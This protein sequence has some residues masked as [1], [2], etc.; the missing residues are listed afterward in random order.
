VVKSSPGLPRNYDDNWTPKY[1]YI[2]AVCLAVALIT[3]NI[4]AFKFIEIF[5]IKFGA[6]TLMFPG[7]LIVGDLTTEVYGFRRSRKVI[8]LS[9]VCFFA[10]TVFTQ[11]A[12]ALPPAPEWKYQD[13]FSTV[14]NQSPRLFV[15]GAL[16]YLAGELSNSYVMSKVKIIND[17]KYFWWR[18]MLSAVIGELANTTVFMNV[19]WLGN[20]EFG[21]LLMVILNGT[22]AKVVIQALVLPITTALAAKFK[23]L[24]G[25]DHFD[26]KKV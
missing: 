20:M 21:F 11:L 9:L 8:L 18:A 5:G 24:E 12:V 19:A 26:G 23:T 1:F 17:G 14:F 15:A 4:I 7:C 6:G 3:T 2:L 22:I 13:A 10:Y 25:V 16:A